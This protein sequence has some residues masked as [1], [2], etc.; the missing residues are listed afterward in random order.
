MR[1]PFLAAA[2][3]AVAFSI[4][5]GPTGPELDP[6]QFPKAL[7]TLESLTEE[8]IAAFEAGNPQAADRPM[9]QLGKSFS[10]IQQLAGVAGLSDQQLTKL[11]DAKDSLLETFAVLHEPLHEDELPEDFKFEP[12]KQQLLDGLAELRAALPPEI[13]AK[14]DEAAAER[15]ASPTSPSSDDAHDHDAHDHEGH[16]DH[17]HADHDDEEHAD[18]DHDDH[19]DEPAADMPADNTGAALPPPSGRF[20]LASLHKTGRAP[21]GPTVMMYDATSLDTAPEHVSRA[22]D[23]MASAPSAD[24]WVQLVPTLHARLKPDLTIDAYGLQ[25][26]RGASWTSPDNF[27]VATDDLADRFRDA[28]AK[29]IGQAVRRGLHVSLL[30][31]LD[32]AGGRVNEWRNLYRFTPSKTIGAGSYESLLIKPLADA[33]EAEATSD[34]RFDLALS[35]EM[36]RS[37]FQHPQAYRAIVLRLRERFA[38]NP[39]TKGVQIGVALNWS[40]LAGEA[41]EAAIDHAAVAELFAELDFIGVSCYAPVSVPP[42]AE[43]FLAATQNFV[44]E[45]R[46]LGGDL[47]PNARLVYSEVGIGGGYPEFGIDGLRYPTPAQVAAKPYEGRGHGRNNPWDDPALAKLRS[48]YYGALCDYLS[49]DANASPP[50]DKAFLWSEGPWDPQGVASRSFRDEAIAASID[51]HNA[52]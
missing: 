3:S 18:H 14:M 44:E 35:G 52:G 42:T 20:R 49:N 9:H 15:A 23:L 17:D 6:A 34:T 41:E 4:G 32:P 48:G 51:R 28:F 1:P 25:G 19:T 38:A 27:T 5:C 40:G 7:I 11:D 43:D 30:P 16:S 45:L 36:G 24:R 47:S 33:I 21:I 46:S 13:V 29:A 39:R 22:A 37:L 10:T 26:S 2:L 8:I 50:I 31:H 12:L